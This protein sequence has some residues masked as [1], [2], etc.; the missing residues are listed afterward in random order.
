MSYQVVSHR[1]EAFR[2]PNGN[3]V[4][5]VQDLYEPQSSYKLEEN[6]EMKAILKI[7]CEGF[8]FSQVGKKS[9]NL[10]IAIL[11]D[12]YGCK[13]REDFRRIAILADPFMREIIAR[14]NDTGFTLTSSEIRNWRE[15]ARSE[16][17]RVGKECRS[18]WSPY[19]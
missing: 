9:L 1:Y 8:Q 16:E 6:L 15:N 10:A 18:R 17:R 2:L 12:V 11:T 4:V 7:E 3:V 5:N 14:Q 13:D 19:H